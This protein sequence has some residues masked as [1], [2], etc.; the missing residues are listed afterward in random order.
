MYRPV[1]LVVTG[2]LTIGMGA[3]YYAVQKNYKPGLSFYTSPGVAQII[4]AIL[5]GS[6]NAHWAAGVVAFVLLT[7]LFI[8]SLKWGGMV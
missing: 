7:F 5:L 2:V 1:V 8:C 3:M 4:F 6:F